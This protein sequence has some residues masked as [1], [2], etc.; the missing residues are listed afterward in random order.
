MVDPAIKELASEAL[1]G[2]SHDEVVA[3]LCRRSLYD[4]VQFAWSTM[5]PGYPFSDN[6]HVGAICEHLQAISEGEIKRLLINI[7]PRCMKSSCVSV[8]WPTWDWIRT[9][10][11]KFLFGSY[12][13]ALS[14]RDSV[15]SR[16]LIQSPWYQRLFGKSFKLTGDQNQKQ[17]YQNDKT[18][19]RIATS[20]GGAMTGDGGDFIGI[21]DPHNVQEAESEAI[22]QAVL[23]WW[24]Q[25]LPTRLND[26]KKGA[27]LVIMQRVH[28]KDLTGHIL[29]KEKGWDHLMLPMRYE[30]KPAHQVTSSL[31]F[32][33]PRTEEGELLWPERFG[34][35]EVARLETAL[36]S[37]GAASQLQQR[38]APAGGGLIKTKNFQLWP[39][40]KALPEFDFIVQ[41]YD[42]AF[43]DKTQNDPT[44]STTWGVFKP[45]P[46]RDAPN[47]EPC[48]ILLDAWDDHLDYPAL[49]KKM[50]S[51][52]SMLY[53]DP[54]R[55]PDLLLIEEKGSGI[56]LV[57]DLAADRLPIATYNP[58]RSDK[59]SRVHQSLPTLEAGRFY[60]PESRRT[61]GEPV[62][63]ARPFLRQCSFFPKGDHDDYVDTFTQFVIYM[64][65]AGWIVLHDRLPTEEERDQQEDRPTK[66]NNPYAA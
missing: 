63:W 65:D 27:F 25:A 64:R 39:A 20:V 23:E 12:A 55:K 50:R 33:D 34:E 28:D 47:P 36:G 2:I 11:R 45:E 1:Q 54:G 19:H 8:A 10:H 38:P 17:R 5:E 18:G 6:W 14:T 66:R 44:A 48:A 60:I 56:A 61:P 41:S 46:S 49:R 40:H 53:G 4:Y 21:D 3:E 30:R 22:R 15:N 29:S 62:D 52:Y 37:Y 31:G 51:E 58:G 26:Q 59:T 43:T 9:P 16:R 13:Q 35:T 7:P 57:R 32:Y 42:T 24:D